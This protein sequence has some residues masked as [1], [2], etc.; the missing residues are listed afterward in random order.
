MIVCVNLYTT[1]I[2]PN[3]TKAKIISKIIHIVIN[4]YFQTT[5]QKR[6]KMNDIL[7]TRGWN[8]DIIYKI[9]ILYEETEQ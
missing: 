2:A 9:G 5:V 8:Y 1:Y 6:S 3:S 4:D 7:L